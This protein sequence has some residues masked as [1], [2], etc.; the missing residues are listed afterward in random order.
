MHPE[1]YQLDEDFADSLFLNIRRFFRWN[2]RVVYQVCE[3]EIV[4]LNVFHTSAGS[5]EEE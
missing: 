1:M 3:K 2:Y 4:I 5:T